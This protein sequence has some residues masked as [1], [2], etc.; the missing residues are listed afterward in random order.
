[1][2]IS[3]KQQLEALYKKLNDE[4]AF[5]HVVGSSRTEHACIN[6][7]SSIHFLFDDGVYMCYAQNHPD[8]P[9]FGPLQTHRFDSECSGLLA[10]DKK[11]TMHYLGEYSPSLITDITAY[12]ML[13]GRTAPTAEAYIT[14]GM[15]TIMRQFG[16]FKNVVSAIP[17]VKWMEFAHTYLWEL[18]RL[19]DDMLVE[20]RMAPDGEIFI[21]RFMIPTLAEI[22][23]N[24]IYTTD[25]MVH[26]DYNF[27]TSTGRPSNAFGG[28][29]FAALNKHDGTREKFVSRFG[30]NGTLVQFDYEAFHLRLA[31]NLM[32]Y[33]LPTTSV[34][35]YLAEQYYETTEIT[36]EMYEESKARTFAIMYGQTEDIG[37][38]EFFKQLRV[39]QADLW[40]KYSQNGFVLSGTGRKVVV[41]KP[42]NPAKVFNYLMQLTETE[43]SINA[44]Y[45]VNQYLAQS[46]ARIVLYTYDAILLDV[47]NEELHKMDLIAH[48]LS[49][50]YATDVKKYPVREYRGEN[51]N[52][53]ILHKI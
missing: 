29:N 1:M 50:A 31:A 30:E 11:K 38:V 33:E 27:Y 4:R 48:L 47:P 25:G 24:G 45:K 35:T 9:S 46:P 20:N 40:K 34:H 36:P 5:V 2:V 49:G 8:G 15:Q 32:G 21:D 19:W 18:K 39:Y 26:S 12:A 53:L 44:I 37:E 22:E 3:T 14:N 13:C 52:N 7:P 42:N 23:R 43:V 6:T 28:T 51:Y 41:P 10:G 17:L 16:S